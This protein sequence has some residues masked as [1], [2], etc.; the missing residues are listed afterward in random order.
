[1]FS[2][3]KLAVGLEDKMDGF[4]KILAGFFQGVPLGVGAGQLLDSGDAAF[5]H[6]PEYC[7]QRHTPST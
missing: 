3:P 7:G 4:L 1:M 6:F 5:R 2:F